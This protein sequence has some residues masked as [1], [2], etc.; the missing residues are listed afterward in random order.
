MAKLLLG[1]LALHELHV[2]HQQQVNIGKNL[3]K[4]DGVAVFDRLNKRAHKPH[5]RQQH[6][7]KVGIVAL[8]F[9]GDGIEQMGFAQA[10]RAVNIKRII[11]NRAARR[12]GGKLVGGCMG[13]GI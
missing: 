11:F 3:F 2:V 7:P 9:P 4:R 10:N 13:Q 6:H 5:R 8:G 12:C 1:R